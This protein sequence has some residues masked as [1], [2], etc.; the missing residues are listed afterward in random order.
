MTQENPA[1]LQGADEG[2]GDAA[3]TGTIHATCIVIGDQ[4]VLIRG[5]SGTGKSDLALRLID[6]GAMLVSDDYTYVQRQGPDIMATPPPEIAGLIEVRGVGLI[7][8][9]HRPS[10]SIA[11]IVHLLSEYDA[12]PDRLPLDRTAERLCGKDVPLMTLRALEPSAPIKV[13][14]ALNAKNAAES[15]S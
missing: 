8:M 14:L 3:F 9:P 5:E 13:E 4:A 15:S 1:S 10:A 2:Q 6:R 11:M 12:D 7:S